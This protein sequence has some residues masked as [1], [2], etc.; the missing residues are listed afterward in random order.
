MVRELVTMTGLAL[1][2]Y[3]VFGFNSETPFPGLSALIPCLGTAL[4][5][6]AGDSRV[7]RAL[8]SNRMM[9]RIGLISYSLYL[10]HWPLYVFYRYQT[11]DALNGYDMAIV[12]ISSIAIAELMYRYI[13]TP[14]RRP[15]K[16]RKSFSAPAF[17]FSCA[18]LALLICLPAAT[19]WSKGGWPWRGSSDIQE[20][21]AVGDK[22]TKEDVLTWGL[23][24]CYIGGSFAPKM[25]YFPDDYDVRNCF[26]IDDEKS[27]I[28]LIGDS[29]AA[30]LIHGLK[31]V[32][33]E[34]RF[35]QVTAASCRPIFNWPGKHNCAKMVD[36]ASKPLSAQISGSDRCNCLCRSLVW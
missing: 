9:L 20:L 5:I 35:I 24:E 33:P 18:M 7:A 12:V 27:N 10:A 4:V 8:L 19:A 17:G 13:E 16:E 32:Y 1:V 6:W 34:V 36:F 29:T 31:Q 2:F 14:F 3:A 26:G 11:F 22:V 28:M 25:Q 15:A 30:H 21:V 23:G